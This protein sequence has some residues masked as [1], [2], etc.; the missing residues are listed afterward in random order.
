MH[1]SKY[2]LEAH[3]LHSEEKEKKRMDKSWGKTAMLRLAG[4][5]ATPAL[6]GSMK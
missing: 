2:T 4:T 1:S 6:F 5:A 3:T